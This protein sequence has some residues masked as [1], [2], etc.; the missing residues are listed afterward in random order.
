MH[1]WLSEQIVNE[2]KNQMF[3]QQENTLTSEGPALHWRLTTKHT[4]R[5]AHLSFT[6]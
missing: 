1:Q 4:V 3:G 5:L 6:L 2:S